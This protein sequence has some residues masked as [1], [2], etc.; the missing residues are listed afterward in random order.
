MRY[1]II[2]DDG[3]PSTFYQTHEDALRTLREIENDQGISG[4]I[5]TEKEYLGGR[6]ERHE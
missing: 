6:Y 1:V 2:W 4:K 5:I 3:F